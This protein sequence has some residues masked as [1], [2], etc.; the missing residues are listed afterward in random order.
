[1]GESCTAAAKSNVE[2]MPMPDAV[3]CLLTAPSADGQRIATAVVEQRLAACAN[4]VPGVRSVFR[5]QGQVQE[6]EETLLVLKTTRSALPALERA[7]EHIHPYD[8][9]ELV[10]LPV[11]GGSSRYLEWI[12][13]SV[14]SDG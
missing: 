9:F 3:V 12:G 7:L 10:A 13:A 4:V 6:E 5:W 14:R 8:T 1:M 2:A 11:Q